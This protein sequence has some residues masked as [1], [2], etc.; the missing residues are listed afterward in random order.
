M[1]WA[2]WAGWLTYIPGDAKRVGFM[3]AGCKYDGQVE[4]EFLAGRKLGNQYPFSSD[5]R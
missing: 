1:F 3:G 4:N 5:G 2:R